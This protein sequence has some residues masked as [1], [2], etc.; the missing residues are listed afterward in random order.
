MKIYSKVEPTKLIASVLKFEELSEYR[1]DICPNE[2]SLQISGRYLKKGTKVKAHKHLPFERTS[3]FTQEAWIV[4][5]GSIKGIIYDID[6]TLLCDIK[7]SRGDCIVLFRGG[8]S[9]E[10]LEEDTVFYECKTGPYY[11]VVEDKK[12][13]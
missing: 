4:L 10:T 1:K 2:E 12:F 7:I 3:Y 11:G 8:H 6:N 13:I 9:L 5:E